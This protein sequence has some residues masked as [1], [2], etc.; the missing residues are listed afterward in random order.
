MDGIRIDHDD[1]ILRVTLDR[2]SRKNALDPMGVGRIVDALEA[3]AVDDRLR[4]VL[5]T[6]TGPDFCSGADWVAANKDSAVRPRPGNLQ[7]RTALQAHRLIELLVHV[8]LPVVCE[9]RGWAAGLGCQIALAADFTTAAESSRFWLPFSTRGF[10]ADSGS[11]WLVPRLVGVARARELLLLGRD[12]SGVQAAEWGLIHRSYIEEELGDQVRALVE[13][14]AA[15]PTTALGLIKHCMARGLETGLT[16]AMELEAHA[17][18]LTS[19]TA[20]FREGLRAFAER[21]APK[22]EGR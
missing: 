4:V 5:I 10:S 8:Q 12:I 3:A 16:E 13:E 18:E 21:R 9:V 17:L 2:P 20:D 11:T 14:L 15:G 7:R 19:R 1:G 22:F 6:A